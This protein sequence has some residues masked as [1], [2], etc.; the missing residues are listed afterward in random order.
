MLHQSSDTM[1]DYQL[2]SQELFEYT[3]CS[4]YLYQR[5]KFHMTDVGVYFVRKRLCLF[6]LIRM[7]FFFFF[8]GG[9]L[10]E[11]LPGLM[12]GKLNAY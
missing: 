6:R 7:L 12:L 8:F 11:C 4:K 5:S 1:S 3:I 9:R 2:G 10:I